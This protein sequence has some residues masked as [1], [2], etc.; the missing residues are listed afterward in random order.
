MHGVDV[1]TGGIRPLCGALLRLGDL[2]C[3]DD[4]LVAVLRTSRAPTTSLLLTSLCNG[5]HR[6]LPRPTTL[7]L[8]D[9]GCSLD[10]KALSQTLRN[11]V[12]ERA[13]ALTA[14]GRQPGLAVI[15]VGDDPASH[16][17]VRNKVRTAEKVG[18]KSETVRLPAD[19][20]E[21]NRRRH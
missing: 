9:R 16:L 10:G 1:T 7:A 11:G 6:V 18:F 12:G 5:L 15:L 20:S 13:R 19:T 2:L 14:A 21:A 8:A 4:V 17:Y 3:L